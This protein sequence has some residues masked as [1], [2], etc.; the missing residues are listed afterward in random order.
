MTRPRRLPLLTLGAA[1][2]LSVSGATV[3][4]CGGG[5]ETSGSA[6][7]AGG[8]GGGGSTAQG[9]GGGTSDEPG[10]TGPRRL[11]PSRCACTST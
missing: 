5:E 3:V 11:R 9:G 10:G 6:A 1:L 2:S 8:G 4:A 7:T